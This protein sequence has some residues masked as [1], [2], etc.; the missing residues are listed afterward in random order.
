M[1]YCLLSLSVITGSGIVW[2][3][4]GYKEGVQ[5]YLFGTDLCYKRAY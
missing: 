3:F 1:F 5:P 4:H 2:N